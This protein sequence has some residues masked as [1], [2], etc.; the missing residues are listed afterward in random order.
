MRALRPLSLAAI[1]AVVVAPLAAQRG[2]GG[3]R[4]RSPEVEERVGPWFVTVQPEPGAVAAPA[5]AG[6][7]KGEEADDPV[8]HL[9]FVTA[10]AGQKQRS[11]VYLCDAATDAE[12]HQAFE[13]MLF[14]DDVGVALRFFSCAR[15]DVS[16][17]SGAALRAQF[18]KAT[19]LFLVFDAT[20]KRCGEVSMAGYKPETKALLET[21]DQAV[22]KANKIALSAFVK[23]YRDVVRD[24]DRIGQQQKLLD[25]RDKRVDSGDK[26]KRAAI[27]AERKDLEAEHKK[28]LETERELLV[29]VDLPPRAEGAERLGRGRRGR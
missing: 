24:L 23:Q 10:A 14:T 1:L 8:A 11:V 28:V 21:L 4:G 9:P 3:M 22:G 26:Q 27:D 19:P 16:A 6:A 29:K 15:I 12:R 25:D 18:G 5:A 7:G 2:G 20:G 17:A 13:R